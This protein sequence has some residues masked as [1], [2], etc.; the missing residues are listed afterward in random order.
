[1][2]KIVAGSNLDEIINAE[3]RLVDSKG[4]EAESLILELTVCGGSFVTVEEFDFP[5]GDYKIEIEGE[6]TSGTPFR[7]INGDISLKSDPNLYELTGDTSAITVD[8]GKSFKVVYTLKNKGAYCT[9]FNVEV[10]EVPSFDIK[11]NPSGITKGPLILKAGESV[12]ITITGTPISA[13]P[14]KTYSIPIIVSNK[15]TSLKEVKP[16]QIPDK[17]VQSL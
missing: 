3:L 17:E 10:P 4:E 16:V 8:N 5:P 15:C 14:G 11:V 7:Y 9:S 1:M 13:T 2:G 12:D 6:D